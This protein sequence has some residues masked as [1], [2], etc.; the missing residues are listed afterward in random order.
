[1]TWIHCMGCGKD[2]A[3][4]KT[5]KWELETEAFLSAHRAHGSV[6]LRNAY[7][8]KIRLLSPDSKEA[9]EQQS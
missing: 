4:L 1:M 3:A 8:E 2:S 9:K 5:G 6:E 7:G